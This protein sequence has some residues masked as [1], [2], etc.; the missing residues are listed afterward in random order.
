MKKQRP[1]WQAWVQF[2]IPSQKKRKEKKQRPSLS[3]SFKGAKPEKNQRPKPCYLH[4]TNLPS[5]AP[6]CVC[7]PEAR[8]HHLPL[9]PQTGPRAK[10][11]DLFLHTSSSF[12]AQ[13]GPWPPFLI[14][15]RE[16]PHRGCLGWIVL[17][18][19]W[20]SRLTWNAALPFPLQTYF[21]H[22]RWS[23]ELIQGEARAVNTHSLLHILL[24][25]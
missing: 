23:N 10:T 5:E 9:L 21:F 1:A 20:A 8:S 4:C 14:C 22:V 19:L 25:G 2:P 6:P 15:S 18:Q 13:L 11:Q 3:G 12:Q 7:T 16:S 17:V 24:W